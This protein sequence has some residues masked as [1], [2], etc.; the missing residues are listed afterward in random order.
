VTD[1]R[2]LVAGLGNPPAEYA[3]TRHNIGAELV[4]HLA[5]DAGSA[6]ARNRRAGSRTAEVRIAGAPVILAVPESFMNVSGGPVQRAAGW[7]RVP[8]ERIVVCH[9]DLDL[10]LG[11][12]RLKRGG[13]HGGHNGLK[14]LDRAFG[15]PGYLRVRIGVGRPPGSTVAAD[16]VLRPFAAEERD[17]VATVLATAADAVAALIADGL[18]TA[19]NRFHGRRASGAG[20]GAD[21]GD[22]V[23]HEEDR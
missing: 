7:Y 17:A 5:A 11:E 21:P 23:R 8:I 9:D 18:E 16:H 2:W 4:E 19:Q 1:G 6:L 10:P 20:P 3:G 12:L 22:A 13:G 15:G 14:D